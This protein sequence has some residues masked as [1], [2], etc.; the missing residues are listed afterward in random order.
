MLKRNER[1]RLKADLMLPWAV[2]GLIFAALAGNV[3]ISHLMGD[4]WQQHLPEQQR[5]WIRSIFYAV[6]IITFPL[7]NLIRHIMVRLNQ[8]MPGDKLPKHRYLTTIIVSMV[9]MESVGMLGFTIFLLGDGFNSLY[10]FTGLAVLGLFLYRPKPD[11]YLTIVEA[12][13]DK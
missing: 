9:L 3:I 11:E 13:A 7:T 6:A 4:Q 12:L 8:T 2:V 1:E 10:I 5:E